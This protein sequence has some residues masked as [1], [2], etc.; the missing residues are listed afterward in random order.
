[1]KKANQAPEFLFLGASDDILISITS[2]LDI[3]SLMELS[4]SCWSAYLEL[5]E[6]ISLRCKQECFTTYL[7]PTIATYRMVA[8]VPQVNASQ[9]PIVAF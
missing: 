8:P 7:Y 9:I 5:Q 6:V 3:D 2:Y 4:I 1:M